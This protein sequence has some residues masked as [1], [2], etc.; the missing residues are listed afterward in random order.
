MKYL[1][2]M[3]LLMPVMALAEG[4]TREQPIRE[5]KKESTYRVPYAAK[6]SQQWGRR[7]AGTYESSPG[8]TVGYDN[9]GNR[10]TVNEETGT[11]IN[12]GTGEVTFRNDD[13]DI[14]IIGE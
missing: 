8:L 4:R 10:F 12:Y 2:L 3:A 6:Y 11:A 5:V 13:P 1:I 7:L 14:I 9:K